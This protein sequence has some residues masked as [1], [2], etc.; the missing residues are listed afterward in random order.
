VFLQ[1][2]IRRSRDPSRSVV[3]D[4]PSRSIRLY[5]VSAASCGL[6]AACETITRQKLKD[7]EETISWYRVCGRYHLFGATEIIQSCSTRVDTTRL[8]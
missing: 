2:H 5:L 7:E 8:G 3:C 1:L 6:A 4:I